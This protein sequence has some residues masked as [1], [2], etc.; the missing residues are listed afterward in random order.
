MWLP[1]SAYCSAAPMMA[2][3]FD[4]VAPLVKMISSGLRVDQ[5]ALSAARA[6]S[7]ACPASAPYSWSM[8]AAFP[9]CS[10]K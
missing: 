5:L 4:S 3:L 6:S 9:K 8:L 2:R 7:T 1:R 10:V